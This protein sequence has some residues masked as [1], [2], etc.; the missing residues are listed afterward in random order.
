[1]IN[2]RMLK[3]S[4]PLLWLAVGGLLVIGFLA[5]F[6]ATYQLQLKGGGDPF[7]FVTKQFLALLLALVGLSIFCYF[8]YQRLKSAAPFLYGLIIVLLVAVLFSGNGISGAQRWFQFGLFSF[9]PSELAKLV[10]IIVL[11]AFLG[12]RTELRSGWEALSL[13]AL[14][15]LPFLLIFKQPD[16]GT[17]LVFFVILIGM[18]A[19]ADSAPLLLLLLVTPVVSLLLR[20]LFPLWLIYLW[21][22]ALTLFL[23]RARLFDW[24]T[25]LGSN[26]GVGI[27][28]PFLWKTLK[29]YQ[30]S[31]IVSFLNPEA[32]PLGAGYHTLQSKIAI[33][34]GGLLGKGFLHGSQ[35]QL[36]FI[37]E[38]FSDFIFSVVGEEFGFL[39]AMVVLGLFGLI[40]W[41]GLAIAAS[42]RDRFG[43]LLAYGIVTML[44][45]HCGANVGMALGIL[46]VVGIP[47]PFLSYGGSSLFIN[48]AAL[49]I[50]QSIS[51]RRQKL[52]F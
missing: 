45:F 15:G 8:D 34:S 36:Q 23:T 16:L 19:A 26:I 50:L 35:T 42:A 4:D 49:G 10:L 11:A 27:A 46:P 20:P 21:G 12:R 1:M 7:I 43:Q 40:V 44:V 47:L 28:L 30:R 13:L 29:S 2:F 24:V 18:L 14:V 51:M 3:L 39:G 31:R 38:Q 25:V 33:G 5:I 9:Q 41:R 6:S 22:V 37:P 17:A 52:I 48:L 32:D